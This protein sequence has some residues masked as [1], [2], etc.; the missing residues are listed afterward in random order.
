VDGNT[1]TDN[2]DSDGVNQ[3]I[4]YGSSTFR[5]NIVLRNGA[6]VYETHFAEQIGVHASTGVTAYCNVLEVSNGAGINGWSIGDANRGN[7]AYPPYQ[8]LVT[9]G[10]SFHHNTVIWD[11]SATGGVGFIHD[12]AGNQPNF[13]ADNTP[14]D[15]NTYHLPST[16]DPYFVYD[17]NDSQN[18]NPVTFADYQASGADVHGTADANYTSGFPTVTIT[19]PPDQASFSGSVPVTATASDASGISQV[20]VY[21]DW[22]LKS[23][24]TSAPYNFTLTSSAAGPH[25]VIA[26]A[27]SNAGV[28]ACYAVTLNEQ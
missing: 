7:S 4:G 19:S 15:Y 8:Y 2:F 24:V 5:N 6:Q 14:P 23:T 22:A 27:Y 26:M 20:E 1:I 17:N 13:F 10:N 12:D 21:L 25:T 16:S 18:N 9:T 3:E 28:R 11:A